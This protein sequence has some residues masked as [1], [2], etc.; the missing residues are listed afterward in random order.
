MKYIRA[1][2]EEKPLP[3]E[4]IL[5]QSKCQSDVERNPPWSPLVSLY[6]QDISKIKPYRNFTR[7]PSEDIS[8]L[9][10]ILMHHD[11]KFATRIIK[12]LNESQHKFVIHID[13]RAEN[14]NFEMLKFS[15]LYPNIYIL[16]NVLRQVVN[17]GGF[18]IVNAT[19]TAMRYASNLDIHYDYLINLSGS[20]YPIKSNSY[21]RQALA[22]YK[23]TPTIYMDIN[24]E[25]FHPHPEMWN[26]W[27]ECDEWLHRVG[28]LSPARGLNMYHGKCKL[29]IE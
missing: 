5:F 12:A 4:N 27:V 21:I 18:S 8:I 14:V 26:H 20:T 7:V 17:W 3:F 11:V 25:V 9:Y 13:K 28:R 23:D 6:T 22:E 1:I 10:V 2:S 29:G 16:P 19:L 24:D 15:S